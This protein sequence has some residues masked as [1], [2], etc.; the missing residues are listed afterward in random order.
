MGRREA[1]STQL[2]RIR[3]PAYCLRTLGSRHLL[4]AG[5]GGAVK[6]GVANEIELLLLTYNSHQIIP[7]RHLGSSNVSREA[8]GELK[9]KQTSVID[10]DIYA[11]MNMD[12]VA[13]DQPEAGKYLIAVGQDQVGC[14]F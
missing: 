8:S 13:M 10:T 1:T 9:A 2:A 14:G 5:G 11:I 6:T 12:I 7:V 4:V 3:I